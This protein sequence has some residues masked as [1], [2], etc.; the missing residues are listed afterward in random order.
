MESHIDHNHV[1]RQAVQ[2]NKGEILP[3]D[4][5]S[6]AGLRR[7]VVPAVVVPEI[8]AHLD[9]FVGR[10][11]TAWVFL[12]PKGARPTRQNFHTIWDKARA[13][14][15]IPDLHLHDLRHTGNTLAAETGATLRE[16]MDRMGHA[17]TRAA[18]VYLHAREERGKSIAEGM[19][20]MVRKA[21]KKIE[22]KAEKKAGKRA[23]KKGKE[24]AK[25]ARK[26]EAG[27]REV[28]RKLH[29]SPE[30]GPGAKPAGR[31]VGV[32][33][34]QE[35]ASEQ[36]ERSP[37]VGGTYER[38][39][40]GNRTRMTSLEGWGSAIELHPRAPQTVVARGQPSVPR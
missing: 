9:R 6:E 2:T 10:A 7:V 26:N 21:T 40:D 17:S 19:D 28:A 5:K 33:P 32:A 29:A 16:L 36:D 14:A 23:R 24:K 22:K 11:K 39:G 3:T 20:A 27:K 12:G 18:L 4:P 37:R 38:A 25:E 15:G 13:A 8:E 1:R 35:T 31:G 30:G 34:P